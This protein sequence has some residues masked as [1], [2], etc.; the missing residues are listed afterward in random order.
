MVWVPGIDEVPMALS[1][2]SSITVQKAGDAT[3]ALLSMKEGDTS[4]S[5]ARLATGSP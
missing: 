3:S 1:S 5:G 4:G 2:P